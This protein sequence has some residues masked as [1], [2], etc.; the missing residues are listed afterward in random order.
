MK[1]I[2]SV[3]GVSAKNQWEM[4]TVTVPRMPGE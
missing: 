1:A 4:N 3:I 2:P